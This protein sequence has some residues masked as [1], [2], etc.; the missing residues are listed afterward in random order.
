MAESDWL[1]DI[2][3]YSNDEKFNFLQLNINSVLGASKYTG[4]QS[5]LHAGTID[6]LIIIESKLGN[7]IPDTLFDFPNYNLV[8][9]DREKGGGGI[10]IF[11]KKNVLIINKIIDSIFESISLTIRIKNKNINL[12]INYN[13]H[14]EY[15]PSF[16]NFLEH[17]IKLT[18]LSF[19]TF[20]IGDLNQNILTAP[21]TNPLLTLMDNYGFSISYD[22]PT[23]FQQNAKSLID[24]VFANDQSILDDN[25]V[26]PC[27]FSNH[28]FILTLLNLTTL[29][30]NKSTLSG[31]VLNE[32]P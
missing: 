25:H 19:P 8:R 5:I 9:R 2:L 6:M 16:N 11:L 3:K 10:L 7:D 29:R 28:R 4:V 30:L 31:R 21:K 22:T 23:H 18:N 24:V 1:Q 17:K 13:P 14:K 20:V 27:P 26:I 15:S 32:H 12:I